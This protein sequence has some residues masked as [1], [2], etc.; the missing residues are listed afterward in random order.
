M[1]E[2]NSVYNILAGILNIGNV[3]FVEKEDQHLPI[4]TIS[5]PQL[6]HVGMSNDVWKWKDEII[7][8]GAREFYHVGEGHI[9]AC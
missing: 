9:W 7:F 6:V 5:N 8:L 3:E 4:V 2:V 1:Q